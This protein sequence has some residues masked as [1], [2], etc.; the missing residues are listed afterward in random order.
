MVTAND[1]E[2]I[3]IDA[4]PLHEWDSPGKK[5]DAKE[6]NEMKKGPTLTYCGIMVVMGIVAGWF[7]SRQMYPSFTNAGTQG[8]EA[9]P[10]LSA[11]DIK[12]FKD[13]TEGMLDS[14]GFD[15][16]GTHK[17]I[18]EGGP[19][20]TAYLLSSVVD[21]DQYIGRKVKVYGQTIAAKKAS[22]LMD[23]GKIEIVK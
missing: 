23:V 4:S 14:G 7:L 18:R 15:G 1:T 6:K 22:W 3:S 5:I 2:K 12:T 20:Q 19:S 11:K 10:T 13:S 9:N 8:M 21:L 16:E 17:L